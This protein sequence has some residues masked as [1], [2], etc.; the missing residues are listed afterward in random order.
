MTRALLALA[1]CCAAPL[2]RAA[3]DPTAIAR[4]VGEKFARACGAGDV[5]AVLALY[6]ADARVIYPGAGETATNPQELE[7]I[8]STTCKKDGPKAELVGYEAVWVDA[9]HAAIASLG[10]WRIVAT[11]PDGKTTATPV[12]AAEV[13]VKTKGGWRYV[14]DHASI[15]VPPA[16]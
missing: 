12:R 2:A 5:K 14:V 10:E 15:G 4:T 13:I 8:V 7:K 1:L 9:S 11:G 6:R 16:P 3:D